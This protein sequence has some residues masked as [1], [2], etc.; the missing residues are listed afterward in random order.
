MRKGCSSMV[1]NWIQDAIGLI[2]ST[3]KKKKEKNWPKSY[4]DVGPIRDACRI[5]VSY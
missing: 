5:C 1:E 4:P 3:E 2:P